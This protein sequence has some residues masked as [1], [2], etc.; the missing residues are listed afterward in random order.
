MITLKTTTQFSVPFG[1]TCRTE[2]IYLT[3]ERLEID[4]N[5]VTPIGYYYFID[6]LEMVQKLDDI[7]RHPILWEDVNSL[8]SSLLP[9]LGSNS[10]LKN[11]LIQRLTEFTMLK[12]ESE[13]DTNYGTLAIDFV[14]I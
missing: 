3:I 13:E 14:L 6:E 5:N 7:S 11:N 10:N 2:F 1:R 8:E 12:L 4:N 9:S